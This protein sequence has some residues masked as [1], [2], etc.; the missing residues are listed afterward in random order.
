MH[1][2][3]TKK[4]GKKGTE[5]HLKNNGWKFPKLDGKYY[6]YIEKAQWFFSFYGWIIVMV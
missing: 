1:S 3:S 4:W 2:G 5:K 6:L